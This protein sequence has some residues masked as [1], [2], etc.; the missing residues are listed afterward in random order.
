[1]SVLKHTESTIPDLHFGNIAPFAAKKLAVPGVIVLVSNEDGTIGLTAHGINHARAN[2]MLSV[3]IHLNLSQHYDL[4][5]KGV[6]GQDAAEHIAALD[7]F[8]RSEVAQ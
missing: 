2:E 8:A 6:A 1:M 4:V 7:H 3:G 5:R